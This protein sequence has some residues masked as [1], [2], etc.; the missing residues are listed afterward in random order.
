MATLEP[1]L[2]RRTTDEWIESLRGADVPCGPV[3]TLDRILTDP[4]VVESGLIRELEGTGTPVQV[5]GSPL[6][7]DSGS[8][9]VRPPPELG[10][11]TDAELVSLGFSAA[12]IAAF[13]AD[14]VV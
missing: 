9:P 5:I 1:I 11:H 8:F 12:E 14:G 4:H 6:A 13:H 7:F 2:A 3:N 10:A